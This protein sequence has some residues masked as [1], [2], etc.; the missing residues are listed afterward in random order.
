M[1]RFD[2]LPY[3]LDCEFALRE[4]AQTEYCTD[5]ISL[6]ACTDDFSFIRRLRVASMDLNDEM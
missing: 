5:W 4:S 6:D 1:K 2:F 3:Y